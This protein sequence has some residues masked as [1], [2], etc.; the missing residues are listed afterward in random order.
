MRWNQVR[1][2]LRQRAAT[3]AYTAIT[4]FPPPPWPSTRFRMACGRAASI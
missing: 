3:R 1:N 2:D 4:I